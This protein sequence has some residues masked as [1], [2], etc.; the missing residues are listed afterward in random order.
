[1]AKVTRRVRE[2]AAW[3]LAVMASERAGGSV[4][5]IRSEEL[6]FGEAYRLMS[7]AYASAPYVQG[8]GIELVYAEAE[9]MLRTGWSP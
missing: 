4:T 5:G 9:A 2:E 1:M 6:V 7:F 8:S 3:A